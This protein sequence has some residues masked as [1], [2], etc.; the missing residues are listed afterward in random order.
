MIESI[1][2]FFAHFVEM[3][4]RVTS[5]PLVNRI[6]SPELDFRLFP[7]FS[8]MLQFHNPKSM[9]EVSLSILQSYLN[10]L[11]DDVPEVMRIVNTLDAV[12]ECNANTDEVAH[13]VRH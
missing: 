6:L 5:W 10:E 7:V 9:S 8:K 3:A 12:R 1:N 11:K 4:D 2:D 13:I